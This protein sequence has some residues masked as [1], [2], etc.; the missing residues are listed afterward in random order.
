MLSLPKN[1][2]QLP[3]QKILGKRKTRPAVNA[4]VAE[5]FRR[6]IKTKKN[7]VIKE[8]EE[9]DISNVA[10]KQVEKLMKL[11]MQISWM[12]RVFLALLMLNSI[13]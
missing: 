8:V 3:D 13:L 1:I 5:D 11:V 6:E 10:N 2:T 12:E 7:M 9:L 4:Y